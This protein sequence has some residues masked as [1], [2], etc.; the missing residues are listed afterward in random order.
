[1]NPEN[2]K[3]EST[4]DVIDYVT[5][6]LPPTRKNYEKIVEKIIYPDDPNYPDNNKE[7]ILS[8]NIFKVTDNETFMHTLDR[9]YDNRINN[10]KNIAIGAGIGACIF[11]LFKLFKKSK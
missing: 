11:G 2:I 10:L 9:V 7:V 8:E 4:E 3:F 6:G 5:K 1:M